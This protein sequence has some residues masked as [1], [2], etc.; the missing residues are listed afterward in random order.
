M[1][2][3]VAAMYEADPHFHNV[4]RRIA[5]LEARLVGDTAELACHGV[6]GQS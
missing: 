3:L 5:F 2:E 4:V 6:F 1:M